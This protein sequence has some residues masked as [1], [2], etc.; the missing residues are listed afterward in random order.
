MKKTEPRRKTEEG[1]TSAN[2]RS[3]SML[4]TNQSGPCVMILHLKERVKKNRTLIRLLT[5]RAQTEMRFLNIVSTCNT[6][7]NSKRVRREVRVKEPVLAIDKLVP[8]P[9]RTQTEA[10]YGS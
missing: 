1:L 2:N 7:V 4:S 9:I 6:L 10:M 3:V 8:S 5:Q